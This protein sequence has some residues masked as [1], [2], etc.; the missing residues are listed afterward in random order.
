MKSKRPHL[1]SAI[2]TIKSNKTL[3]KSIEFA[4]ELADST[5]QHT[6]QGAAFLWHAGRIDNG[7]FSVVEA[8]QFGIPSL[9]SDYPAMREMDEQ[10]DLQLQ[11]MD[12]NDSQ[13]MAEQLKKLEENYIQIKKKLEVSPRKI[14]DCMTES[15]PAYWKVIRE[16][17]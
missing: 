11:W 13:D 2:N 1:E 7:T 12:S 4:G 17:L 9:S 14:L 3:L 16:F 6:L 10:F 15:A 5:Y 8:R